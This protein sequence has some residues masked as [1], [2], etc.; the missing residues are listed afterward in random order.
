M[1]TTQLPQ[2]AA[3]I[4][5]NPPR[6]PGGFH[7]WT[8]RAAR[9]LWKCGRS[10][11]DIRA[12]LENAAATC[13]RHVP[14]REIDDAI[15]NSQV[16]AFQP[17]TGQYHTWPE[18][19][20]EQ[21][22]AVIAET[23]CSLVDL[24]EASP[25]KFTD[26]KAHSEETGDGLFPGNPLLCCGKTQ[27]SFDTKPRS[28]WRGELSGLQFIVPSPMIKWVGHTQNGRE[29]AH[30]KDATGTR[31]FLVIEQDRGTIDEQAAILW[32][33]ACRAPLALA[34]H[35]GGKSIHGWFYCSGQD[36]EKVLRPFMRLAV[37]LGACHSTWT[38]SQFVR[39]PDGAR[40]DGRRQ[41]VYYFR[42]EVIK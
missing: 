11:Y 5:A 41:A 23:Q 13:G 30:T 32:H 34:V 16:S 8:F 35:S 18:F 7:N 17:F 10:E 2:W 21:R 29:S 33:L 9:A 14:A 31:R 1:K 22:R 19:N 42:P 37:S 6:S 25:V 27:A 20:E 26:N 38:K 3:D 40:A 36:E 28:K 12:I 4:V 39:M 24:W 15:R